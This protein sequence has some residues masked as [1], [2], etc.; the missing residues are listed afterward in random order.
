MD[1]KGCSPRS[2]QA[3]MHLYLTKHRAGIFT[4]LNGMFHP[5]N[6]SLVKYLL[7][8]TLMC[9]ASLPSKLMHPSLVSLPFSFSPCLP[10]F[11]FPSFVPFLIPSYL[12]CHFN[13]TFRGQSSRTNTVVFIALSGFPELISLHVFSNQREN[14][15]NT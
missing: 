1:R 13:M 8:G 2:L 15:T 5:N 11:L 14:N 7:N 6:G 12:P 4:G 10:S 9:H 3:V